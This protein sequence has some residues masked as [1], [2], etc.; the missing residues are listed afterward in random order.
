[1]QTN[2]SGGPR[3]NFDAVEDGGRREDD[4]GVGQDGGVDEAGVA[5][6]ASNDELF[7]AEYS[8][9]GF[10]LGQMLKTFYKCL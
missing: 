4:A 2:I 8:L 3:H 1:M 6:H 9:R 7:R 5:A 10:D